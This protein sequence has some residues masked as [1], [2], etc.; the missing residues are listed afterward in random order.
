MFYYK[1]PTQARL[2]AMRGEKKKWTT[3]KAVV[4]VP[5]EEI[6]KCLA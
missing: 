4:E 6:N 3:V 2:G 1:A 5:K